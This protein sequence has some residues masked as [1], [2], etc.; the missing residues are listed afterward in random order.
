ML[1]EFIEAISQQA[2]K[3]AGVRVVTIPVEPGHRYATVDQSGCLE[4]HDAAPHPRE[5]DVKDV[6][7]IADLA[8]A[9]IGGVDINVVIWYSRDGIVMLFNDDTRRDVATLTLEYSPQIT[10][11]QAMESQKAMN[12][13]AI[14]R[15]LRVV[16]RDC[17]SQA[18][19]LIDILRKIKFRKNEAGGSDIAQGK[20]SIGRSI[21]AELSGEGVI[22]DEVILD[23]PVFL[24]QPWRASVLCVLEADPANECFT[25]M[26]MAGAIE[27]A[28]RSGEEKMAIALDSALAATQASGV[29]RYYGTP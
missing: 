9:Y 8:A 11:L 5:H 12:Q 3:A 4:F 2:V 22:P 6:A 29:Q 23:V 18:G 25:L 17:L 27:Q 24:G 19:N 7:A 28:I 14:V 13:A 15:L 16:F 1:K 21:Q 20:S 10:S 26:P